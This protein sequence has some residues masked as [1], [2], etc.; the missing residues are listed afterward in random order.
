VLKSRLTKA[1]FD[2]LPDALKEYYKAEGDVYLLQ[3]DDAAELRAAKDRE[4]EARRDAEAERDRLKAEKAEAERVAREAADE[5]A[6][7]RAKKDGDISALETSWQAKV[8]A[9]KNEGKAEADK[10]RNMLTDLLVDKEALRIANEISTSPKLIEPHIRKR[11]KAELDG[12][13]P[14]T[15]VLDA[16]GEPSALSLEELQQEFVA[17]AD[18][19]A[20]IKGSDAS[21]GGAN[22]KHS[23]GGAATKKISEMN[24]AE[25]VALHKANPEAFRIK[26]KAEGLPGYE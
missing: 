10:L 13:K 11:L 9:A 7:E 14:K 17:N 26:A 4:A 15:R 5:A 18:F 2:A 24:Q 1:E 23:G 20:I 19:A 12:D 8:D 6:R 22:G 25:R 16:A 3:S 21:G